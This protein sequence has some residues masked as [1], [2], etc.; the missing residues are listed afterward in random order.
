MK[1]PSSDVRRDVVTRLSVVRA[2]NGGSVPDRIVNEAARTVNR[3]PRTIR[4]WMNHKP[5]DARRHRFEV[6]FEQYSALLETHGDCTAAVRV[7]KS[8]GL[9]APSVRTMQRG[10]ERLPAYEREYLS[11][12]PLGARSKRP[13]LIRE[14]PGRFVVLEA[15]QTMVDAMVIP[16]RGRKPVRPWITLFI[17]TTTKVIAG[18]CVSLK[19]TQSD[20]LACMG[21]AFGLN[22]TISPAHGIPD[23][24]RIDRGLQ[25]TADA[26]A[27][28][29]ALLDI[30]ISPNWPYQPQH[31]G[32]VER[33]F[34]TMKYGFFKDLPH[35]TFG[36]MGLDQSM[37]LSRNMEPI[38]YKLFVQLALHWVHTYNFEKPHKTLGDRT[39]A[40]AWS[41]DTTIVQQATEAELLRFLR[42][43]LGTRTV[44]GRGVF[45]NNRWYNAAFL[46]PLIE[47]EVEIRD[48]PHDTRELA[49][50]VDGE[51]L[52]SAKPHEDLTED[53]RQEILIARREGASRASAAAASLTKRAEARF[54]SMVAS[55]DPEEITDLTPAEIE[56]HQDTN[57]EK[58]AAL[59][60]RRAKGKKS[61]G[62][63]SVESNPFFGNRDRKGGIL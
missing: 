47:E 42:R 43:D 34:R 46:G 27:D 53:E 57:A 49:V 20:V 39:P 19:P 16:P 51:Y 35:A 2:R 45:A 14:R 26:V 54:A 22:P 32:S 29:A 55:G 12:G 21:A 62:E 36:P 8:R 63:S 13:S 58:V 25:F 18:I 52:G 33:V 41:E 24:I 7:L 17:C 61:K 56:K 3:S 40:Q 38:S 59:A 4:R 30:V 37:V 5:K 48:I 15:D 50:F 6:N 23:E 31:K 60:R 9:E 44:E 1:Q 11:K 10:K 28:A